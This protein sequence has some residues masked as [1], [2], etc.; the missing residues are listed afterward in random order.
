PAPLAAAT[1]VMAPPAAGEFRLPPELEQ[2]GLKPAERELFIRVLSFCQEERLSY[3]MRIYAILVAK[4]DK[5]LGRK[6]AKGDLDIRLDRLCGG[7][8]KTGRR[9]RDFRCL[10]QNSDSKVSNDFKLKGTD[11]DFEEEV[12]ALRN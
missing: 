11:P 5:I 4:L 3:R 2:L 7:K 10:Y 1:A 9:A 6:M 8:S 12:R